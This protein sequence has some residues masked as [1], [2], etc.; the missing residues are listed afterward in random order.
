MRRVGE[1]D[2]KMHTKHS[3]K[4]SSLLINTSFFNCKVSAVGPASPWDRWKRFQTLTGA[5]WSVTCH[6]SQ[7]PGHWGA[8]ALGS[9]YRNGY[10]VHFGQKESCA[11]CA[12]IT[13][14]GKNIKI[15]SI[16]NLESVSFNKDKQEGRKGPCLLL[17]KQGLPLL[18]IYFE[19]H[20]L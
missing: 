20:K 12:N 8:P 19:I 3:F 1:S 15:N 4:A 7:G 11:Y 17:P 13:R 16:Q 9:R 2:S 6:Q 18:E 10:L 5:S 14:G